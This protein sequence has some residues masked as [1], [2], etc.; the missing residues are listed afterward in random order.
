MVGVASGQSDC[1][2][3]V[4]SYAYDLTP[5]ARRIGAVDLQATD[6]RG[7]TYYYRVCGVVSNKLCQSDDDMTP[8][9][10]QTDSRVPAH[11]YGDCGNQKTATFTTRAR[12]GVFS[13]IAENPFLTYNLQ[14]VSKYAC[15]TIVASPSPAP[16][17]RDNACCLYQ[18]DS[19][20]NMTRTLCAS[21]LPK[22]Q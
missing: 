17:S 2:G 8:A 10:C 20:P 11:W 15:P 21:K 13:F 14:F 12:T 1:Q 22:E 5:L 4:G 7:W 6:S 3:K 16:P 19:D 9:V 18:F